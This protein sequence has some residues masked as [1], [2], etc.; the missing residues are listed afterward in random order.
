M[1]V[2]V[3]HT[4][5]YLM[6][7]FSVERWKTKYQNHRHLY[8]LK[9]FL[10]FSKV[11][12]LYCL[13]VS[14]HHTSI[15][16]VTL[17]LSFLTLFCHFPLQIIYDPMSLYWLAVKQVWFFYF[18]FLFYKKYIYF[19]YHVKSIWFC[20]WN[21]FCYFW[22]YRHLKDVI[23]VLDGSKMY[24]YLHIYC[25]RSLGKILLCIVGNLRKFMRSFCFS[26]VA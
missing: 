11:F 6:L 24:I 14:Q 5:N 19:K 23:F 16:S 26:F 8:L 4:N 17:V 2:I 10:S 3:I 1:Y 22:I 20:Y 21:V 13:L 7:R 25:V 15:I 9:V 12:H 18:F